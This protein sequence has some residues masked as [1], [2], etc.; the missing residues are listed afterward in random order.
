M[1]SNFADSVFALGASNQDRDMRYLKQIKPRGSELRY[2]KDSVVLFRVAKKD[3]FLQFEF[4]GYGVEREH[5]QW[6][7]EEDQSRREE[8]KAEAKRLRDEGQSQRQISRSL[9]VPLTTVHRYLNT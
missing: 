2:D 6:H 3:D 7:Y 1:L 9:A 8:L 5:L 4:D